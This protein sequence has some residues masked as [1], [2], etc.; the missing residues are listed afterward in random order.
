MAMENDCILYRKNKTFCPSFEFFQF[1]QVYQVSFFRRHLL[2]SKSSLLIV[3]TLQLQ[4]EF[5]SFFDG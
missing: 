3:L 4:W 5:P 1:P 2:R